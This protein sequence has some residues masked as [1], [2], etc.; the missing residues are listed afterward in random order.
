MAVVN[1]PAPFVKVVVGKPTKI[2]SIAT[3]TDVLQFA[4][5]EQSFYHCGSIV[6]QAVPNGTVT[7]FTANIAISLD[8]GTTFATQ[9]GTTPATVAS[10][11][12][13]IN[14]Q[15]QPLQNVAIPAV[16]GQISLQFQAATLT[17][18]TATKIDIWA[19]VA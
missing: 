13:A 5:S 2:G 1:G 17:L 11:T 4:L 7:T 8:G 14:F 10:T 18:G 12:A 15:T 9:I 3:A 16:G 6:F 19:L